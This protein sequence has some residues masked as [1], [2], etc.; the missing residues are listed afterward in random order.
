M[1]HARKPGLDQA[2]R[3]ALRPE[4]APEALRARLK[5]KAARPGRTW[6]H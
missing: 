4:P 2:L 5:A 1:N 6:T 3:E